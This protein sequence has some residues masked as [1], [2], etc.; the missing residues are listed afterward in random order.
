MKSL[1]GIFNLLRDT[2]PLICS[3]NPLVNIETK[4]NQDEHWVKFPR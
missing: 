4:R 1:P 3:S 2:L